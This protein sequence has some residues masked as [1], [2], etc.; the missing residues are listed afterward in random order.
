M[1]RS[2]SKLIDS[3]VIGAALFAMFFGAGNMIFP[4]YLGFK[5]GNEWVSGFLSYYI[6]DIGLALLA[7]LAQTKTGGYEKLLSPFGN[8]SAKVLMFIMVLCIGPLISIPRTAATTFELSIL[9][10]LPKMNMAVF[11]A[12]FFLVT[13]LFCIKKSAV[14]DLIGKIL[15]PVLFIGLVAL[16]IKGIIT[17]LGDITIPSRS[18][19]IIAEGIEAGYQS[20]D[21]LA[22][23]IFGVLI[24][25]SAKEKGYTTEKASAKI[26]V[27]AGVV[28]SFGLLIIYLGLSL[29]GATA[30]TL[31]NMH[32]S[33]TELLTSIVAALFSGKFGTVFFGVIAGLACLST[34]IAL[35][36]AAA[37]YFEKISGGRFK[38]K[39]LVIIICTFG[40]VAALLGV[41]GL[42]SF[43]SP[44]LSVVYPPILVLIL[45][46]FVAKR[47]DRIVCRFSAYTALIFGA[48]QVAASFGL[49]I[50]IIRNL[51][52]YNLGLGWILPTAIMAL[53]GF[54]IS[55]FINKKPV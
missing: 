15:T 26:A 52:L 40:A 1:L 4:P 34:A 49:P 30:C 20:M 38:Y 3:F 35:T 32:I 28:A 9:P 33:R 2:N 41:D 11:Y 19:S 50:S 37:E 8:Y 48:L 29:L 51:P 7:I 22:A 5:A 12:L 36:C 39:A 10:S 25:N 13:A 23:V 42:V 17:P 16:I 18:E 44:L 24:L 27:G 21:V 47:A 14:V 55:K 46:A 45:Y 43:A 54:V 6:A 53:I 31:Y